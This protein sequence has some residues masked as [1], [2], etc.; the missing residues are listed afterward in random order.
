M[1]LRTL[2]DLDR[3]TATLVEACKLLLNQ[4]IVDNEVRD[5]IYTS[6]GKNTIIN[7][8]NDASSLIRPPDDLFYTELEQR[9]ETVKKFLSTLLRVL[10]FEG[11]SLGD[12]VIE[13]LNWLKIKKGPPPM[14][15]ISKPWEGYVITPDW[16]T[17]Y[18]I[19]L[20]TPPK[21]TSK[22][23][24]YLYWRAIEGENDEALQ[25]KVNAFQ[26]KL[27]AE[28][29]KESYDSIANKAR[30][31]SSNKTL[32]SDEIQRVTMVL[33]EKGHIKKK[34]H[35]IDLVAYTFCTLTQ[36][37]TAIKRRDVFINSSWRYAD[38]CANLYKDH[39]WE[40]IS[41]LICRSLDL[42]KDALTTLN[43][44]AEELDQTYRRVMQNWENNP[45]VR[46]D[47]NGELILTPLDKLDEPESL[48]LLRA[49]I[50]A[51][52]P[53]VDLPEMVLEIAMKTKFTEAFTHINEGNARVE[54]LEISLCA[55]LLAQACNTGLE[56][57]VREDIPA[58]KR[59]RLLWVDQYYIRDET[60]TAANAILVSF[61]NTI[62]LAQKWGGGDVASADGIRFIVA[63]RTIN[64]APNPKYFPNAHGLTWYNLLSN[65]RTGLNAI[66]VPGTLRDSL[67]LLAVVLE[68]QTELDPV[69]IMTD[70][71]AY[72]DVVFGLFRLVGR[73]FAPR[74]ADL[75]GA[76]F[77][78]VDPSADYGVLNDL[79]KNRIHFD[80]IIPNWDDI[81]RLTGSLKLGKVPATGIM[82]TLQVGD[83]PT[84][85]AK[86][87]AEIGRIDKTIHMLNYI[88][89]EA[90]RR[91]TL[92]QLNLVEGRHSLAREIFH[93][94]RGEIH[95]HYREG[96]EDQLGALGL[97]LN[98]TSLWNT[99]Y[100]DAIL[101]ELKAES[102][103]VNE[104]DVARLSSFGSGHINMLGRYS[105]SMPD[106][107]KKGKL[108]PFRD[109]DSP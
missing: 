3:S 51:R 50:K 28:D 61:Q 91:A 39:E 85:L 16:A 58:L 25:Y 72:S 20:K 7:A 53:Q 35:P 100:T 102:F 24:I 104:E 93:G 73:R 33:L 88:D 63:V 42:T 96:Q 13:A 59:D 46:F 40:T 76:R 57:F 29:L 23:V 65:Q 48:K 101:E 31:E 15:V 74:L 18:T 108:R 38:P 45:A 56:P 62:G 10:H 54:D 34:E 107:V 84:S 43:K 99:L 81:L 26:E 27:T 6:L 44:M 9:K 98:M 55:V 4:T 78:R 17:D 109:S 69:C 105:F 92:I 14:E 22:K 82:R 1:R 87:I 32:T 70:T 90:R 89:D 36:L 8:V 52:M 37:Q 66:T 5:R 75:G 21:K 11:N 106:S 47:K 77:W 2:K 86:A 94:K 79:S 71:G 12:I 60:L 83:K 103:E 95:E 30:S 80:W 97:V 41:P 67:I 49:A 68:Q 19:Q 64:A